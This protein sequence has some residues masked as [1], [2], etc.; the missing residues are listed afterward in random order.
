MSPRK[1]TYSNKSTHAARAAHARGEKEFRTY[2]TSAIRPK[3]SKAPWIALVAAIAVVVVIVIALFVNTSCAEAANDHLAPDGQQVT[4]QI[5]E[6]STLPVIA[7]DLYDAGLVVRK[8]EFTSAV[9]AKG[10]AASLQSGVYT[11][12]GGMSNDE[13]VDA[14]VAGPSANQACLVV[15]EGATLSSIA[16]AVEQ[17]YGGSITASDFS[18][19]ASNAS[20][21]VKDYSFLKDAGK[22][23]LEGFLFPKTY[24]LIVNATAEDVVR[25]MLDQY[26]AEVSS[27][28]YSYP[29][30]KGMSDYDAL[31]LASIVEKEGTADTYSKVAAVFYNRLGNSGDPSYGTLGSDATTA[32]EVGGNLDNYDWSKKSPYNTRV[33]K[34]LPPTPICSPSIE[35]LRAVLSPEQNFDDYYFFS[36][37]NNDQGGV[38]YYFD[39]TYDDHQRTIAEHS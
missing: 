35:S 27:L 26:K 21:Y 28:D 1:V 22:N 36:F 4:V 18:S 37:W 15:P 38:D 7:D 10:A 11:L 39:K 34:G 24:D 2:D 17:A 32:Y 31:I 8:G 13:L 5:T 19:A 6:G 33:T 30:N 12:E 23:S 20:K 14:L 25:Q 16:S 3:K 29:R 9:N